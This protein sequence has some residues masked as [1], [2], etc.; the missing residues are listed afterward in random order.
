R[1]RKTMN[2]ERFTTMSQAA[3]QEAASAATSQGN[4]EVV[5]EHLVVAIIEQTEGIGRPLLE[6]SHVNVE[7]LLQALRAEI[8]TLPRVEGGAEPRFGRRMQPFL[9]DAEKEA[10]AL[11]D[12]FVSTEH[13]LL[14]ASRDKEKLAP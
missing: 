14:A 11:K 10:Q 8:A 1:A 12:E 6:L 4:P 13:F 7:A 9:R 5:P 3:I 2:P